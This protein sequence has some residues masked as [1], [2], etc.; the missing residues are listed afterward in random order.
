MDGCLSTVVDGHHEEDRR[1]R[2][3]REDGLRLDGGHSGDP[4]VATVSAGSGASKE[5]AID[6]SVATV[7]AGSGASKERAIDLAWRR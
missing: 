3:R 1:G 2:Q 5:R 7:S 4:S 6:P